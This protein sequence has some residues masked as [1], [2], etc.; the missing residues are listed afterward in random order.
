[1]HKVSADAD[2]TEMPKPQTS[3]IHQISKQMEGLHV[4]L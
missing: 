4:G 1:M 2:G 3:D